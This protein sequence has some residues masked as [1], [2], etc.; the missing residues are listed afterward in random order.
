MCI[1]VHVHVYGIYCSLLLYLLIL[2]DDEAYNSSE[3][4]DCIEDCSGTDIDS[5][6]ADSGYNGP[7]PLSHESRCYFMYS[8]L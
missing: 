8:I 3:D 6:L 4:N 5:S 7:S 2:S 1:C